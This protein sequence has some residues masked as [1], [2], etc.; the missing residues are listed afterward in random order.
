MN[1]VIFANAI[2]DVLA[3][4]NIMFTPSSLAGFGI[5]GDGEVITDHPNED[6]IIQ[7]TTP[8]NTIKT[9]EVNRETLSI[10]KINQFARDNHGEY[11]YTLTVPDELSEEGAAVQ[12]IRQDS[13]PHQRNSWYIELNGNTF[14]SFVKQLKALSKSELLGITFF[15]EDRGGECVDIYCKYP[16]TLKSLNDAAVSITDAIVNKSPYQYLQMLLSKHVQNFGYNHTDDNAELN[17]GLTD[18]KA[19]IAGTEN[20]STVAVYRLHF[21]TNRKASKTR[22]ERVWQNVYICTKGANNGVAAILDEYMAILNGEDSNKTADLN[23]GT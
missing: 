20:D 5:S 21:A 17:S 19:W 14:D 6:F 16:L 12:I 9:I 23:P 11:H 13:V 1:Q 22:D 3:P 10:Q 15:E 4:F 7:Y 18:Y 8:S 2:D